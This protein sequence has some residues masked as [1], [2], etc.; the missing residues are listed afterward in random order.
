MVAADFSRASV[1]SRAT[2]MCG[3]AAEQESYVRNR[4]VWRIEIGGEA[5]IR[6]LDTAFRPYNGLANRRLRPL[7]HLTAARAKY[8]A[9]GCEAE[10]VTADDRAYPRSCPSRSAGRRSNT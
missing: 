4:N 7:G 6:T 3:N 8:T 9:F 1:R 5:G 2:E 10:R